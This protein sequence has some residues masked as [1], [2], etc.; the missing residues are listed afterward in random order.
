VSKSIEKEWRRNGAPL[1]A[2][3]GERGRWSFASQSEVLDVAVVASA[4]NSVA[5]KMRPMSL[6]EAQIC[7]EPVCA[8]FYYLLTSYDID[9]VLQ[10]SR[11]DESPFIEQEA[12]AV[13]NQLT[14]E[15]LLPVHKVA[16][17]NEEYDEDI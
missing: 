3:P 8:L 1:E 12:E 10:R 2:V 7:H 13:Q 14:W 16:D 17:Q 5:Q 11:H 4:V 6:E 15:S 9:E